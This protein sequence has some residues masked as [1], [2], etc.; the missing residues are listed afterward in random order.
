MRSRSPQATS[1][2]QSI[3]SR[4][5]S[6]APCRSGSPR[7]RRRRRRSGSTSARA[8]TASSAGT[9]SPRV[10]TSRSASRR[11][12]GRRMTRG[13]GQPLPCASCWLRAKS[14]TI[15]WSS[16]VSPASSRR[17]ARSRRRCARGRAWPARATARRPS[18]CRRS[19][20]CRRRARR[21]ALESGRRRRAIVCAAPPGGARAAVVAV[22]RRRDHLEARHQLGDD[23]QPAAPGRGEA[24]D[25]DERLALAGAVEGGEISG[26]SD[27]AYILSRANTHPCVFHRV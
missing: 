16:A 1:T 8:A 27:I 26:A 12:P 10:I 22:Q 18:S 5:A 23:R 25:E 21:A 13:A 24:V 15:R 2:G 6:A 9:W 7:T 3:W 14:L 11:A 19:A 20:R 17:R 4:S